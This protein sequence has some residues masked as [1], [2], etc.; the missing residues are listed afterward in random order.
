V[1]FKWTTLA[2]AIRYNV[3]AASPTT[4]ARLLGSTT[5]TQLSAPLAG[6]MHWWVE[7]VFPNG[8]PPLRSDA[9]RI[10]AP[11]SAKRRAVR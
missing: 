7:A 10:E 3:Y 2:G 1:T 8:C 11:A 9:W 5:T 6:R 4:P